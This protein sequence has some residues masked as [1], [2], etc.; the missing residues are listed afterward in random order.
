MH[1]VVI[2]GSILRLKQGDITLEQVD[3]IVNAANSHLAGG[4]GVDGAIHRAGGPKIMEECRKYPGCPTGGAV[5]TSGGDLKARYVIHAVG[6]Y[7]SGKPKDAELLASAYR[8][9]L[10]LAS[11]Y[12]LKTI[13]FPAISTGVYRYPLGEAAKISLLTVINYLKE[14]SGITEV[15]FVLYHDDVLKE[16]SRTLQELNRQVS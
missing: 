12:K 10:E 9:S 3:A 14:H 5:I 4:G 7:Y 8:K 16:Y 11:E 6:P 15:N 13:S 2:N 1:E